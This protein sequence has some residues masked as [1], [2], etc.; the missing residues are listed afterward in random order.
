MPD[1]IEIEMPFNGNQLSE[2][3][4]TTEKEVRKVI[5]QSANKSCE[6]DPI[7]T[8]LLK[9]CLNELLPLITK[10]VNASL[11][12]AHVPTTFKSSRIR[13]LIKKP[14]LD[15]NEMKNYRP[16]SNL[17]F[18]SKILEKVVDNQLERHLNNHNLH[19]E[20]QSAY[21]KFHSTETA[22][23]RVQSDILQSLDQNEATI[24]VML[25]LSAAFDTIDHTTLLNRLEQH[26][27]IT[28]K[29]LRWMKS[30]LTDRYQTVCIDGELSKP[31]LMTYSVPQGSVLGP[32]NYSLY[33]KPVG[34]I[35]RKHNLQHHFY[36]DDSQLYMSF[37]PKDSV[38][39]ED[40]L[41]R[42][43]A[44]VTDI[45]LWMNNNLL[46]INADKTEVIIFV[47]KHIKTENFTVKNRHSCYQTN[48]S[49]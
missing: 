16:V 7:P 33:T 31:V 19:E 22:L 12:A 24:L 35:C 4:L 42:I 29:P 9:E 1:N 11:Q 20:R 46:K 2:F 47:P 26:F 8:W 25:D 32:K 14:G 6:L 27:G 13:P 18:I 40:A 41:Q 48:N 39:R 3:S 38:S 43:E 49:C 44:C 21:R 15:Q 34:A 28:N 10:L 37:K 36:A 5:Q 45:V 23:L 17:P 30:Y